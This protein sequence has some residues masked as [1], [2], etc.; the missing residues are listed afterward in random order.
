M[1]STGPPGG[2]EHR[3]SQHPRPV[4]E[5]GPKDHINTRILASSS[6]AQ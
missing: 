6:K 1:M 3:I 4:M 2:K 5:R